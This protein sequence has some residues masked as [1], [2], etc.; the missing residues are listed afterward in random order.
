M[1][2]FVVRDAYGPRGRTRYLRRMPAP[3]S[4]WVDACLF[5]GKCVRAIYTSRGEDFPCEVDQRG[6]IWQ[7]CGYG[8]LR[9]GRLSTD[10]EMGT[11]KSELSGLVEGEVIFLGN[12]AGGPRTVRLD[13]G[14]V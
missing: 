14:G 9:P 6:E 8:S 10:E 7:L 12:G 4:P 11:G 2:N 13:R 1:D 5:R 3:P